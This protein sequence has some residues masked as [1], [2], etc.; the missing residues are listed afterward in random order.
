MSVQL[1]KHPVRQLRYGRAL[2]KL[3]IAVTLQ[4]RGDFALM[5]IGN[6][7]IPMISLLVWQA[8]LATGVTLPVS[9]R[10]LVAYFLLVGLLEM[11]TASWSAF[12]MAERI[13]DGALNHWLVRPT[14]PHWYEVAN[15]LGE[16]IVKLVLL[17]PVLVVLGLA[18]S[19][20]APA[21][22]DLV[23]PTDPVNWLLFGVAVIIAAAIRF[24]LDVAVGSLAFW[25]E[26]V[27]GFLRAIAVI[28]PVLSGGVVPLVLM[29]ETLQAVTVIQPFRFVI[30]FPLE[31]L[32]GADTAS[33][34]GGFLGQ[35][36][37][38]VIFTAGAVLV[39]RAGLR[40]YSAAGA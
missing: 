32:L 19:I 17:V 28:I 8:V 7:V 38:L 40:S 10:Y 36:G 1:L 12:F 29:P 16:K 24:A 9:G 26:D 25:F 18:L 34:G 23:L 2:L 30:S 33:A 3:N 20:F 37:W 22:L 11:L 27:Q 35:L 13:R 21:G 39:W 31:V 14:S 4:Y 5:Q 6:T 15:N